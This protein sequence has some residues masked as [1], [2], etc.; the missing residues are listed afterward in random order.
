MQ[1]VA[2]RLKEL[3][4]AL[5]GSNEVK[6]SPDILET[7]SQF[8]LGVKVWDIQPTSAHCRPNRKDR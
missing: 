6:I 1:S 5:K 4:W 3:V 8:A 2:L 7:V